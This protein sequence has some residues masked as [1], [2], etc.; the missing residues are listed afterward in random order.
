MDAAGIVLPGLALGSFMWE[1]DF[2]E[3]AVGGHDLIGS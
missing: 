3:L 1:A 2:G